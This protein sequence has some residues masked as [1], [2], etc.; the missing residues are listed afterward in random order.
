MEQ[1]FKQNILQK[2]NL[3]QIF[4]SDMPEKILQRG[5]STHKHHQDETKVYQYRV[6]K[7]SYTAEAKRRHPKDL[8]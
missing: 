7:N 4:P 8:L 6:T 1:V 3:D 2:W 5:D